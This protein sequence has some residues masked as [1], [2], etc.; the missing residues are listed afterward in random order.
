[1]VVGWNEVSGVAAAGSLKA[2]QGSFAVSLCSPGV[3]LPTGGVQDSQ[4]SKRG[5]SGHS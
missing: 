5:V 4:G 2:S 1:M 3:E